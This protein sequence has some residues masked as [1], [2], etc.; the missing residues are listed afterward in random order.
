MSSCEL[1]STKRCWGDE[2]TKPT[3]PEKSAELIEAEK[4]AEGDKDEATS[5]DS[6]ADEASGAGE[7]SATG[8][9]EE[10]DSEDAEDS[11]A[12]KLEKLRKEFD[13]A[14]KQYD[15]DLK[16]YEDYQEKVKDGKEKAEELNRRFA[17]WYYVIP[18]ESYDKLSLNRADLVKAK[19][20]DDADDDESSDS[21]SDS[22]TDETAT[23][24][25]AE[26]DDFLAENTDNEGIVTTDSGLQYEILTEG[27]GESPTADS[28]VKVKYKGTLL[29]GTVFDE[30]G[31][32]GAEFGVGQVI[33]GWTEAL[34]LM[35]PG[36]K[37][38]LYIPP[39]L[40]YG[41]AG[42]GAKIG[43]NSALIFEVEL[44]SFE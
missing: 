12:S 2:P 23:S 40:A 37:W 21:D 7:E 34:Q 4:Q 17:E 1:I 8:E 9:S 16:K 32:T 3:E 13:D 44:L 25:Q 28:M 36:S 29:D 22:T 11:E 43:P 10:S 39:N 35:K 27:E 20:A 14:K 19:E 31:D 33:K 30:S 5:T 41:E 15:E 26:A 6:E 18:G 42:S 24:N 38:K